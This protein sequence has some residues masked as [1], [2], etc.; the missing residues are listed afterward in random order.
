MIQLNERPKAIGICPVSDRA[1][2]DFVYENIHSPRLLDYLERE[3]D[4][5]Q[6]I[7]FSP[8]SYGPTLL[9]VERAGELAVLLPMLRDET[10]AYLPAVEATVH[11]ARRIIFKSES[12]ATLAARL[13]G[14]SIWRKGVVTGEGVETPECLE[15]ADWGKAIRCY[16]A[17]LELRP[18]ARA[19]PIPRPSSARAIHQLVPG[20]YYGDA[21]SNHA[22]FI[23]EVLH[24]L[25]HESEIFAVDIDEPMRDSAKPFRPGDIGSADG[26]LFHYAIGS[27]L[28]SHAIEHAG[29]KALIYHNITPSHFLEPWDPR[30]AAILEAGRKDLRR[31]APAFPISLGV[32]NYNAAELREIGFHEPAVLPIFVDPLRWAR[33]ADPEWMKMLQDG[34]TNILF[35]GRVLPNKC[36]HHLLEAFKEYLSFDPGARLLLVGAWPERHPYP[37]FLRAESQRLGV[38]KQ[39]FMTSRATDAQLLACYRASHIFWSMSEH[40]GFCVP[41][42]EA[43]WFDIPVLAYRSSAV[44]ETLGP[45]GLMFTEK[46][47]WAE[48]AALAH[49]LVVDAPLRR[50]V[51]AAQRARRLAFLPE[52]ILPILV[53]LV[54]RLDAGGGARWESAARN[55]QLSAA[56][57]TSRPREA[58]L[59]GTKRHCFD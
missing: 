40:E 18:S 41:L 43:M 47:R 51:I 37:N 56:R 19:R 31:L 30:F 26:L 22:L 55:N 12:E 17:A 1:A 20:L 50:T 11:K 21:I 6:S 42:I 24:D 58:A 45:A 7:V 34:R 44:P 48:L 10:F 4:R 8:Y 2:R 3:R 28:T 54:S 46:N 52:A 36:Q 23:R 13:Y 38:E 53:E 27:P 16:E 59:Q 14:P 25:G 39:V 5:Y 9:G 15:H 49:L 29:P 32:S 35:V 33:P 57:F